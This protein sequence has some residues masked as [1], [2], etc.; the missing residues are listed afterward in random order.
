MR[1]YELSYA[2]TW[3]E[4]ESAV[5]VRYRYMRER[6]QLTSSTTRPPESRA[7]PASRAHPAVPPVWSCQRRRTRRRTL[8]S[9]HLSCE[10]QLRA[11]YVLPGADC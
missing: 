2:E 9:A 10:A 1:A 5:P 8:T 11:H 3:L 4:T 6:G 7:V